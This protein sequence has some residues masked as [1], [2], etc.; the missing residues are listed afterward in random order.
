M[1]KSRPLAFLALVALVVAS[2]QLLGARRADASGDSATA[3]QVSAGEDHTCALLS[4]GTIECWGSG[5]IGQLGNGKKEDSTTPVAVSG[6]ITN[7]TQVSAGNDFNCALISD[8]TIKCWGYN[9]VGELGNG[10]DTNSSVPVE[11]SGI[12]DAIAIRSGGWNSCALIAGGTVKCWGGN[13]DGEL[14]N[15]T[16]TSR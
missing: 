9:P 2:G 13:D 7:A 14:G 15:G 10:S 1:K 12:T 8:G 11:V 5:Y 4:N 16:K 3:T 6:G